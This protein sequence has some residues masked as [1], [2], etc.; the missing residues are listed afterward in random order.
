MLGGREL[1]TISR[2]P[3]EVCVVEENLSEG[4]A[5]SQGLSEATV[6]TKFSPSSIH[7]LPLLGLHESG[8]K[9]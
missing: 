8:L 2:N 1:P 4:E 6:G 9:P 7:P 5:P 3:N